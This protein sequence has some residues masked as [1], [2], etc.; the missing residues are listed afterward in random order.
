MGI[1]CF[2]TV[3]IIICDRFSYTYKV[4]D[5]LWQFFFLKQ[6]STCAGWFNLYGTRILL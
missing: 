3:N 5:N 1:I 4:A 6:C 2:P